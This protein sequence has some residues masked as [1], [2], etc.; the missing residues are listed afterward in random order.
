MLTQAY[1]VPL[2]WGQCIIPIAA[3]LRGFTITPSYYLGQD[4]ADLWL[5]R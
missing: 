1:T 5:R 2:F 3:E 4:L